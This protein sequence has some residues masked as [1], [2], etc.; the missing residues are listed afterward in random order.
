[1]PYHIH[2][3]LELLKSVHLICAMLLEVPNMAANMYDA[4]HKVISKAFRRL[5][6]VSE[7]QTFTCPPEN[8]RD[9]VM[10]ATL[11]LTKGEFQKAFDVINSLD[12]R[13]EGQDFTNAAA[14]GG[15]WQ[16]NSSFIQGRQGSSRS[17]YSGSGRTQVLG[18]VVEGGYSRGAGH[19]RAG[20]G[21]SGGSR[22]QDGSSRMVNLPRGAR[23]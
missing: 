20:G 9:H 11:A 1:M 16:E 7:R 19:L 5:L 6:E 17:G 18:Q 22:Y 4:K 21:Y 8:V 13:R 3:N 10:A 23:A 12:R 2:I 14:S 15:K